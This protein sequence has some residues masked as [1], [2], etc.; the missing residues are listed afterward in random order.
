MAADIANVAAQSATCSLR[1]ISVWPMII[2]NEKSIY[3]SRALR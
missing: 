1:A 3:P 2:C